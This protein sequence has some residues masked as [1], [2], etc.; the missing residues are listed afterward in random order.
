MFDSALAIHNYRAQK[1][2]ERH[3]CNVD[4]AYYDSI[5]WEAYDKAREGYK[6]YCKEHC[7]EIAYDILY[8]GDSEIKT[9]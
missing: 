5:D 2:K 6:K 4:K 7:A 8:G 3:Q 9:K 1:M